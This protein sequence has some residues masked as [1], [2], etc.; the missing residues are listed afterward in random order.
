MPT[1]NG[2][3]ENNSITGNIISQALTF[4]VGP[5]GTTG[6]G[7]IVGLNVTDNIVGLNFIVDCPNIFQR[8]TVSNNVIIDGSILLGAGQDFRYTTIQGNSVSN[9]ITPASGTLT[10]V[11]GGGSTHIQDCTV[12]NNYT[13][14]AIIATS[15]GAAPATDGTNCVMGNRSGTSTYTGWTS[16]DLMVST[17]YPT[18]GINR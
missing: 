1:I 15:V 4:R 6:Q 13:S 9:I 2:T 16:T 18:P 10:I 12:A 11:S 8:G 3:A 7:L 17:A 14:G 5:G